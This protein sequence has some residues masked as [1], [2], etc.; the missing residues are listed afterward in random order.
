MSLS[1]AL[2]AALSGVNTTQQSLSVIAGNVANANTPGYVEESVN[3][4]EVGTVG[5][6]GTSVET[7]GI[8]RNLNQLLQSQLWTETSGG[9][10]ADMTST[11]Y[12]QLQNI[13]GTPNSS[14][15]FDA[16]Y[17]NFTTALQSLATNPGSSTAQST[18]VGAAQSLAQNL[19][20]MTAGIQQIRTQAEQGISNDVQ[21]ANTLIQQIAQINGQLEGSSSSDSAAAALED[22]RDQDVTQLSQLMNVRVVQN[23]DNQ[24][25]VFTGNGQ[26]LVANSQASQL[27][28][29]NAGTLSATAQWSA[30]PSQDG[31]GTI[32]LTVPGGSSTDLLADGAI[33]SGE[34]AAYVQMRDNILPQAQTQLDEMANQM[35]QALSNQTTSGTAVTSGG[36]AGYSVDVGSLLPGNTVRSATPTAP[37]PST[38]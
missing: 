38:R 26:Q 29:D 10:Y 35:S 23:P 27:S 34:I 20:S 24:I 21:S 1:Q 13:Y 37:I 17:N 2:S 8:N 15:S 32:T 33:Q 30:D 7:S 28:F 25:S 22:Q 6:G 3:Q 12:Q 19:N 31:V 4:V 5:S 11:L 9:S 18:V 36:Q 14:T 16:I